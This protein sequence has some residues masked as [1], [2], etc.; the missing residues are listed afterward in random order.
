MDDFPKLSSSDLSPAH[1]IFISYCQVSILLGCSMDNQIQA[2]HCTQEP[3]LSPFSQPLASGNICLDT[4]NGIPLSSGK[5]SFFLKTHT[6]VS[7]LTNFP[8]SPS[9][10]PPA[11]LLQRG[12]P[13]P[14]LHS[15]GCTS[16]RVLTTSSQ[17]VM[18]CRDVPYRPGFQAF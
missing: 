18:L 10:G 13:W 12:K 8:S 15:R 3:S 16:F 9:L 4:A 17:K 7:T 2:A 14:R 5:L 11:L 6:A 1:Q